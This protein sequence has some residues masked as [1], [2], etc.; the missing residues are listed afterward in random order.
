MAVID[1][2][3]ELIELGN[4]LRGKEKGLSIEQIIVSL[5]NIGI[6]INRRKID[7]L[8]G[9]MESLGARIEAPH[10]DAGVTNSRRYVMVRD[11]NLLTTHE[12][13]EKRWLMLQLLIGRR[14]PFSNREWN[15]M[16]DSVRNAISG[17]FNDGKKRHLKT[18]YVKFTGNR[19]YDSFKEVFSVISTCLRENKVARV[20]YH[21]RQGDTDKTYDIE[22][23]TLVDHGGTWYLIC[24][25]PKHNRDIRILAL[26]RIKRPLLTTTRFT[27]P[28]GYDPERYLGDSFG[29]MIEEPIRVSVRLHSDHPEYTTNR[30]WGK[31]QTIVEEGDSV[32]L[33]FTA[34]GTDEIMRWILSL[35]KDAEA[36][37]PSVLVEKVKAELSQAKNRYE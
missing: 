36:L 25:I 33:S 20:T 5:G 3:G 18:A 9:I 22:P 17:S 2:I 29:I 14:H 11:F 35:G 27:L 28:E 34:A 24:G 12:L 7:R 30:I 19:Y 16:A 37:G 8:F 31:E 15:D 13:D 10:D 1:T 4:I 32:V 26:D 23:Y 6:N 21:A